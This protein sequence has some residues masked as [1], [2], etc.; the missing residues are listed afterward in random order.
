[1]EGESSHPGI[2]A[3]N[4]LK[5]QYYNARSLLPKFDELLISVDTQQ[6]DIICITESWLCSDIEDSEI[7]IPGY[8]ILRHDRNRHGGGVLMYVS[9]RFIVKQLPSHPS[10]ELFTVTLHYGNCRKCLSLFYRPVHL[11]KFCIVF[12]VILN[13]LIFLSFLVLYLSVTSILIF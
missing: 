9:H 4:N 8:Q 1:M 2:Q 13:Q 11:L 5:I 6:P 12:I 10:L 3:T 7:M